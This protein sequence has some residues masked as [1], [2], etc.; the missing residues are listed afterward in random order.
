MESKTSVSESQTNTSGHYHTA[1]NSLMDSL[2]LCS[3]PNLEPQRHTSRFR[4]TQSF[5]CSTEEEFFSVGNSRSLGSVEE[6][7]HPRSEAVEPA[8]Q[9]TYSEVGTPRR[10]ITG[11]RKQRLF[12]EPEAEVFQPRTRISNTKELTPQSQLLKKAIM[13]M[14]CLQRR[15]AR[16]ALSKKPARTSLRV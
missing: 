7:R 3:T 2:F 12:P 6:I 9:S 4:K 11:A 13:R 1:L 8:I 14:E 15:E 10:V 16:I 5:P